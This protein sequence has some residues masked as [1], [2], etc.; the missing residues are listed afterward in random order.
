MLNIKI[1]EIIMFYNDKL[2]AIL[3]SEIAKENSN[4]LTLQILFDLLT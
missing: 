1:F 2:G 4:L 3:L